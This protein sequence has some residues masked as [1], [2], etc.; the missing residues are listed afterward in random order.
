MDSEMEAASIRQMHNPDT[1]LAIL[2]QLQEMLHEINPYISSFKAAIELN[3]SSPF[4]QIVLNA[5]K[6]P[7]GEHARQYNLPQASEVAV[8]MPGS[9]PESNLDVIIHTRDGPL[10]RINAIHRS[11]DALHY[12]LLLP[13]G[14]DGFHLHLKQSPNSSKNISPSEFYRFHLQVRKNHGNHLLKS[15]RLMQQY[16]CDQFAKVESQR[17]K[18]IATHQKELKADK[19]QGLLDAMN[20]SDILNAGIRTI[21]PP[22]KYMAVPDSTLNVFK[23]AWQLFDIMENQHYSSLSHATPLGLR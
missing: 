20:D 10:K 19:Y 16:A 3:K 1:E 4:L 8:I 14:T 22:S 7:N 6:R 18:Y 5:E 13:F 12:I 11:Y 21:L 2:E 15:K 23:T 17:L 9:D